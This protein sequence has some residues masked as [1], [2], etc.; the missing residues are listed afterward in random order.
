MRVLLPVTALAILSTLFLIAERVD[1]GSRFA[2]DDIDLSDILLEPGITAPRF[3][4]RTEAGETVRLS[5]D[6]VMGAT[7]GPV[8]ARNIVLLIQDKTGSELA[9][10]A[11]SAQI[12]LGSDEIA[13]S[14]QVV[15]TTSHGLRVTT[16][17]LIAARDLSLFAFPEPVTADA[18]FGAFSANH[19]TVERQMSQDGE[20]SY[21]LLFQDGVKLLY[22]GNG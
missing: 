6:E 4:V 20:A 9:L 7:N 12:T 22:T 17:R 19:V 10:R 15:L 21:R 5:A 3:A 8:S 16:D 13:F 1:T 14:G 2:F 18:P 11:D